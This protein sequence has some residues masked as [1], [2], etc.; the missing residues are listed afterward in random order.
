MIVEDK[1][2]R[3]EYATNYSYESIRINTCFPDQLPQ[4][5]LYLDCDNL[6]E[7][8]PF[9]HA[10]INPLGGQVTFDYHLN[11][12]DFNY[13]S[14]PYVTFWGESF[15]LSAYFSRPPPVVRKL[16]YSVSE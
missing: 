11:E 1:D 7:Y 16:T 14:V 8:F 9:L 6:V 4:S 12:S 10:E 15:S 3:E 5:G 13:F 2:T